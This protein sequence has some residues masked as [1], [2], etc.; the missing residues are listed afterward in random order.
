MIMSLLSFIYC[1]I[2]LL[3][4]CPQKYD[5]SLIISMFAT[6]INLPSFSSEPQRKK[7]HQRFIDL[8]WPV[9]L[10]IKMIVIPAA[11]EFYFFFRKIRFDILS[12]LSAR[13]KIHMVLGNRADDSHAMPSLIFYEKKKNV[14]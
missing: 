1:I 14:A 8:R 11:D 7:K 5:S 4:D 12:E 2:P 13:Q 6:P 3:T 9:L 10:T